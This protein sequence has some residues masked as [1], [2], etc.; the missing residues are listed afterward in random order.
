MTSLDA[1]RRCEWCGGLI[2][3]HARADA[4]TCKKSCRQA[5]QRHRIAPAVGAA[6]ATPLHFGYADPPYPGLAK[7]YYSEDERC[8]EVDHARLI[9][10][11][12]ERYPAGWALSTS[13][14]ALRAVLLLC[15]E[16]ARVA[17]WVKGSR[18]G[19][20][21]RARN[22]WEPV[23][24]WGGRP[25]KLTCHDELDDVLIWGGRQHSHPDALV[26][27][28]PAPF[29]EWVFKQLGAL[30]G[31]YLTDVFPGSGAM[32]RDWKEYGGRDPLEQTP[33]LRLPFDDLVTAPPTANRLASTP[34]RLEEAA[35]RVTALTSQEDIDGSGPV[36]EATYPHD[37][38]THASEDRHPGS[39]N[40]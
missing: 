34:S 32:M 1:G 3:A 5:L 37:R 20:S 13:A 38:R 21:W 10:E 14:K 28:K 17:V 33:T 35:A 6:G 31:D 11:L 4:R 22:A 15:P 19:E 40:R 8:A 27:M 26:G 24:L 29:A 12:V 7:R 16:D 2:P 30:A 25:T 9:A 18:K 39:G 23:I 36:S